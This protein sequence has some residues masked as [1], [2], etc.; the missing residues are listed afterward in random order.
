MDHVLVTGGAR[1]IGAE[2]V[3]VFTD[4]GYRVSFFFEK[5][6]AAA[7]QLMQQTGALGIRCDVADENSVLA[8]VGALPPTDVL[9]NNAAVSHTG[10]ISQVSEELW[11]R[12]FAVNVG[13]VF[14]CVK[15]VLPSMLQKQKGCI[16]NVSSM[17]GQ[18]GASCEVAYSATKGAV[19]AMTKALAQE[20]GPS[21]IRVNCVSPGVILTDMCAEYG[22][23][24]LS[25][26]A[27]ETLVGRNGTPND[28]AKALLYLAQAEFV[29]GEDLS[30]NGGFVL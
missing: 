15:A 13:G 30:V 11:N 27:R 22:E 12:L 16:L 2:T 14:H 28:V 10:L 8:A 26:L 21:G 23:Q 5:N 3:R 18:I 20:L 9:I 17:W 19:R 1:G 24:T 6:E 7:K 4:A 25:E 29:T